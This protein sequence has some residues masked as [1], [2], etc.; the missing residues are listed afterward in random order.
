MYMLYTI[1]LFDCSSQHGERSHQY[2][3][4]RRV[5][6][7]SQL[8]IGTNQLRDNSAQRFK[9]TRDVGDVDV[10]LGQEITF[11]LGALP[12]PGP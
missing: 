11:F 1:P 3:N 12:P 9:L 2:P 5:A 10:N 6:T 4:Q 7:A 8:N